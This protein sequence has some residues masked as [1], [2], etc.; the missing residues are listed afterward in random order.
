MA[1]EERDGLLIIL[2]TDRNFDDLRDEPRFQD[3]L[4]KMKLVD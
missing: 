3:I 2:K 1:L 4:R